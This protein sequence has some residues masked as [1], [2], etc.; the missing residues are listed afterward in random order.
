MEKFIDCT[1]L[2]KAEV[3]EGINT[4]FK[5]HQIVVVIFTKKDGSKRVLKGTTKSELIPPSLSPRTNSSTRV[6]PPH[7]KTVYDVEAQGFR[8]IDY[9]SILS[10]CYGSDEHEAV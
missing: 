10:Y 3:V 1:N 6:M 7:L 4:A 2:P 9:N 5:E 8:N